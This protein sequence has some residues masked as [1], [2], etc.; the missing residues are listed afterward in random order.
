MTEKEISGKKKLV[1]AFKRYER[2]FEDKYKPAEVEADFSE[3]Y[4]RRMEALLRQASKRRTRRDTKVRRIAAG[5]AAAIIVFGASMTV[6]AIR[7]PVEEFFNTVCDK[8]TAEKPSDS[9]ENDNVIADNKKPITNNYAKAHFYWGDGKYADI[10]SPE[11]FAEAVSCLG[12]DFPP[13]EILIVTVTFNMDFYYTEQAKSMREIR[14]TLKTQEEIRAWEEQYDA[15][16]DE[17]GKEF[18]RKNM[19]LLDGMG[20]SGIKISDDNREAVM[21]VCAC[22]INADNIFALVDSKTVRYVSVYTKSV[23]DAWFSN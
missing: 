21:N 4:R 23:Y 3:G 20:Y 11:E 10:V 2:S 13:Q 6:K 22:E 1:E 7:E 14:R 9:G 18:I 16:Y 15:A 19:P 8:L 12:S 17:Y 5:I